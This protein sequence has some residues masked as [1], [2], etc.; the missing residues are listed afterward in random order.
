MYQVELDFV[1]IMSKIDNPFNSAFL[2]L[3]KF[4]SFLFKSE[5]W[6]CAGELLLNVATRYSGTRHG[7][8]PR[9]LSFVQLRG[10][11]NPWEFLN[12]YGSVQVRP[13]HLSFLPLC[14]STS[15]WSPER[16]SIYE[17]TCGQ[18]QVYGNLSN[19]FLSPADFWGSVYFQLHSSH[20]QLSTTEFRES[21][22]NFPLSVP[23]QGSAWFC[24]FPIYAL[25]RLS[26]S[27]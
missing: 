21:P 27:C 6:K 1:N 25:Q 12:A 5:L 9:G 15:S 2:M 19:F 18:S 10:T 20:L 7:Q 13:I 11:N 23:C 8:W 16:Y 17:S 26:V 3:F 22:H 4:P 24:L 14:S